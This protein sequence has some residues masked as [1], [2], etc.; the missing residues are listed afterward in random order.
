MDSKIVATVMNYLAQTKTVFQKGKIRFSALNGVMKVSYHHHQE[1]ITISQ[2]IQGNKAEVFRQ[3]QD[4]C[5][6]CFFNFEW[7]GEKVNTSV[8]AQILGIAEDNFRHTLSA[9][10]KKLRIHE[11]QF[12][13]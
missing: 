5:L 2:T 4:F 6:D 9:I 3:M 1:P 8:L 11:E 7:D 13:S 12:L 10:Y